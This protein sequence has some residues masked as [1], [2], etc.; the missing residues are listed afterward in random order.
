[1][2]H[3]HVKYTHALNMLYTQTHVMNTCYLNIHM[4]YTCYIQTQSQVPPD[5]PGG[6]SGDLGC[7][8]A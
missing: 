8:L 7:P 3:T 2:L 1:M 4:L 6:T 5:C